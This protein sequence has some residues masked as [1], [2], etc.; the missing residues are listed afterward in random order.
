MAIRRSGHRAILVGYPLF[1]LCF[2]VVAGVE[3]SAFERKLSTR[4][5]RTKY[6]GLRGSLVTLPNKSLQ[7]VE[8]FMGKY[9]K[10]QPRR[11]PPLL[12]ER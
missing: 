11:R 7:P 2:C 3:I 1:L 5:V 9:L 6:G 10:G 4:V 12:F 8:V